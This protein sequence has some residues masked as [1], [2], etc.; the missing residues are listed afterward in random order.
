MNT[1]FLDS[2]LKKEVLDDFKQFLDPESRA[3]Y[4]KRGIPYRRGYLFYGPPGTGKTSFVAALASEFHLPIF[5]L[6]LSK[7]GQV[8]TP[9]LRQLSAAL[10]ERCILLLEDID[11][12]GLKDADKADEKGSQGSDISL[13]GLL[14]IID[15]IDASENHILIMSANHPER[16]DRALLRPG[17][18]DKKVAF[19]LISKDSATELFLNMYGGSKPYKKSFQ[20]LVRRFREAIPDKEIAPAEIQGLC[21]QHQDPYQVI[22]ALSKSTTRGEEEPLGGR[23]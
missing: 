1:V 13:A 14:N 7:A 10:P 12:M 6:D 17:R 5:C 19:E 20:T 4:S 15:G 21:L 8:S 9:N 23:G 3:R 2:K 16:L 18:V 11:R 22:K